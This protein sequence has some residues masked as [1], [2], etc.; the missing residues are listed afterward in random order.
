M[1]AVPGVTLDAAAG[2][3]LTSGALEGSNVNIADSMVTMIQLAR[4]FELQ[5][6]LMKSTEDNASAASSLVRMS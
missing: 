1:H 2:E 3:T 5:T 6:K 4:Q